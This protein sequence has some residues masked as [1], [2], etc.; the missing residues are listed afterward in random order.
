MFLVLRGACMQLLIFS[1]WFHRF[2]VATRTICCCMCN[3]CTPVWRVACGV[4]L[5]PCKC[6]RTHMLH[7][8][9]CQPFP[10]LDISIYSYHV[11]PTRHRNSLFTS[12]SFAPF[13][14]KSVGYRPKSK[15]SSKTAIVR[16]SYST[17]LH[18]CQDGR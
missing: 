1:F 5:P 15:T 11:C 2:A 10:L 16:R 3:G 18:N 14:A 4:W 8:R 12:F 17:Y 13:D 6:N 7:I 9:A